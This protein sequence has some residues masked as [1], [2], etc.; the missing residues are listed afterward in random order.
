MFSCVCW[1]FLFM[2]SSIPVT[3][4]VLRCSVNGLP[5]LTSRAL[6]GTRPWVKN[7]SGCASDSLVV[8]CV[9]GHYGHVDVFVPLW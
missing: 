3:S 2:L 9:M 4:V 5:N 6:N 1:N 7:F 8:G